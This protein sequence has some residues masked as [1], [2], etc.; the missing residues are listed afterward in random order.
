ML[1]NNTKESIAL[2]KKYHTNCSDKHDN[3]THV[4]KQNYLTWTV[5]HIFVGKKRT[6]CDQRFEK[7]FPNVEICVQG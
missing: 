6:W 2:N 5:D 1:R 7:S 3:K 4:G